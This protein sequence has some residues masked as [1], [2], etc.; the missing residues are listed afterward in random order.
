MLAQETVAVAVGALIGYLVSQVLS[1]Q[2]RL[3]EL[4]GRIA[5]LVSPI[6][7]YPRGHVVYALGYFSS[8][9]DQQSSFGSRYKFTVELMSVKR[10]AVRFSL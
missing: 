2:Q 5:R 3:D 1:M 4:D 8:M 7:F 9:G 10:K 6:I